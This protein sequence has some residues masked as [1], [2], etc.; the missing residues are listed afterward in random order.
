MYRFYARYAFGA[1]LS[2]AHHM[3]GEGL[4]VDALTTTW[5]GWLDGLYA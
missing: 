4:D 5:Q 3:Y 1:P 2:I